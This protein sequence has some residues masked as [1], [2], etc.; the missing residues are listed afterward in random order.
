MKIPN[1]KLTAVDMLCNCGFL[2]SVAAKLDG[3]RNDVLVRNKE[4]K[5]KITTVE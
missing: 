4:R 1:A 5:Y 3:E 2:E